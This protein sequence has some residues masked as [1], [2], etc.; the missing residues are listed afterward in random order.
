MSKINLSEQMASYEA[1]VSMA[2]ADD[3]SNSFM[4]DF[5][6]DA[7][8][9]R[10]MADERNDRLATMGEAHREWAFNVGGDRR[11]SCW[12]LSDRDVWVRNPHY[13]G[14]AEPHPE[15]MICPEDFE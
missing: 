12:I 14:P 5:D 6:I 9:E 4:D 3:L 1:Y 8:N 2:N 13:V 11:E 15:D 7:Y 10:Q